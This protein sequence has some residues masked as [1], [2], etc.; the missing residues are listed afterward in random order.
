VNLG[1]A[2]AEDANP[3]LGRI[4]DLDSVAAEDACILDVVT[5]VEIRLDPRTV[6]R[7]D[8]PVVQFGP[9]APVVPHVF[10]GD[11]DLR[12]LGHGQELLDRLA[13]YVHRAVVGLD[14]ALELLV[15]TGDELGDVAAGLVELD[16]EFPRF[17]HGLG[18]AAAHRGEHGVGAVGLGGTQTGHRAA[19]HHRVDAQT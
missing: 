19:P 7:G 11:G 4:R 16:V 9:H 12:L 13:D 18:A 1:Q 5:Y 3:Y 6:E 17:G 8:D 14:V 10:Q 15:L 2:R